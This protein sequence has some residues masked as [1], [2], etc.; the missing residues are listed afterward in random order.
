VPYDLTDKLVV[1]ISSRAL[2]DLDA[3]HEVFQTRGLEEHRAHQR[4]HEDDPLRPG[5]AFPLARGLLRVNELAGERLV[6]VIIVSRND[7]DTGLRVMNSA[8]AAGLDIPRAAFVGGRDP[9]RY[10]PA[11]GCHLFLSADGGDVSRALADGFAA[12]RILTVPDEDPE[13]A[14]EEVRIAFDGDAVLFSAESEQVFQ[15]DGLE[16]FVA[17]EKAHEHLPLEPG[18]LKPFLDALGRI[19]GHFPAAQSPVRISLVTARA[20]PTHRRVIR[21]LRTWGVQVDD[22]FFLGG[23]EKARVLS[24]LRPHIFFDDQLGHLDPARGH[25][26]AVQIPSSSDEA[27]H[28][29]EQA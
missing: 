6:E 24:L 4:E 27:P 7:A 26:P 23:V 17:H 3:S 12:G 10:L 28:G 25:T 29:A 1:A 15:D 11:F 16:A 22:S 20:A 2:F 5:T 9:W 21:T 18:P 13:E 14:P 8:E 19:Q